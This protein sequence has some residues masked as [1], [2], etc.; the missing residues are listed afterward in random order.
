MM[1]FDTALVL[2]TLF[3]GGLMFIGAAR[4]VCGP[5]HRRTGWRYWAGACL[6]G[7]GTALVVMAAFGALAAAVFTATDLMGA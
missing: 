2:C 1:T 7:A 3:G 5:G 4:V 6:E